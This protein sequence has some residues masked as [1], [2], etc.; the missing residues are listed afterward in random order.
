MA[1][2]AP[3]RFKEWFNSLNPETE[4]L[5]LEWKALKDLPFQKLLVLRCLRPDRISIA[6]VN[7]IKKVL[8]DGEAFTELD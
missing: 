8:P 6:L 2:D 7:F 1:V 4:N 5:P 3:S